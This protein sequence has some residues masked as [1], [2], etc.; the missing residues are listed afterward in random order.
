MTHTPTPWLLDERGRPQTSDMASWDT[1]CV[2]GFAL[3]RGPEIKAN[4]AR[5]V[6][7]VNFFHGRD[8]P[9]ENIPEGGFKEVT[10]ALIVAGCLLRFEGTMYKESG[11][12]D[13][14]KPLDGMADS[15]AALLAKLGVEK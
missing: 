3:S 15:I 10:D 12:P 13:T 2:E 14:A 8:I 7:C 6:A 5:I 9:T 11:K 4:T 1:I